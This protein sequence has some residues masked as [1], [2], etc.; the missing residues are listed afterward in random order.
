M[1]LWDVCNTTTTQ[2]NRKHSTALNLRAQPIIRIWQHSLFNITLA[3]TVAV[4]NVS[5]TNVTLIPLR[6][7]QRHYIKLTLWGSHLGAQSRL[8][9]NK[10]SQCTLASEI[11]MASHSP[12]IH[13]GTVYKLECNSLIQICAEEPGMGSRPFSG[14]TRLWQV[15]RGRLKPHVEVPETGTWVQYGAP[16]WESRSFLR[17]LRQEG[18]VTRSIMSEN[19]V[20]VDQ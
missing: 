4:N 16:S 8:S 17:G 5:V 9:G 15:G 1:N 6:R 12:Y 13:T 11:F 19:Q 14:G 2:N 7:E 10:T 3:N 20:R 18:A